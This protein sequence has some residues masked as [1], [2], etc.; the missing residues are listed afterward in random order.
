MESDPNE[1]QL[2]NKMLN[3]KFD[4]RSTKRRDTKLTVEDVQTM[5]YMFFVENSSLDEISSALNSSSFE[6]NQVLNGLNFS[7][8]WSRAVTD[9]ICSGVDCSR[10]V[11]GHVPFKQRMSGTLT[12]AQVLEVRTRFLNG[13]RQVSI[14]EDMDLT[15]S[16]VSKVCLAKAYTKP[17]WFPEGWS[18]GK[19]T[20]GGTNL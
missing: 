7:L 19:I 17:G 6:A 13:E 15:K 18:F 20:D 8:A 16:K 14:A 1:Y 2:K 3:T 12:K 11:T 10:K 9:L 4:P 5:A